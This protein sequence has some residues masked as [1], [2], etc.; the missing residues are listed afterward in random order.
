[1]C[2]SRSTYSVGI[3]WVQNGVLNLRYESNSKINTARWCKTLIGE[4]FSY[5]D[6]KYTPR[7]PSILLTVKKIGCENFDFVLFSITHNSKSVWHIQMICTPYNCSTIRDLFFVRAAAELRQQGM[8]PNMP[9]RRF[10]LHH[11]VC[12]CM[13]N[14]KTK[15]RMRAF[16]VLNDCPIVWDINFRVRVVWEG[17]L[18]GN[19]QASQPL[20]DTTL[21]ACLPL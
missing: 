20:S 2:M 11:F 9:H 15:G 8:A 16:F 19:G 5:F 12:A 21:C 1:M 14:S 7:V 18:A 6:V 3:G 13:H 17:W 4:T 10:P